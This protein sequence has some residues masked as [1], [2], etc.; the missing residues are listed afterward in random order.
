MDHGLI[1]TGVLLFFLLFFLGV[2]A[3]TFL[4]GRDGGFDHDAHLPLE[5]HDRTR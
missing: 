1:K 2:V 5:D 3:W 4:R